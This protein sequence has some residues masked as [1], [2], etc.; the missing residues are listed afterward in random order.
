MTVKRHALPPMPP[1]D[2]LAETWDDFQRH[3]LRDGSEARRNLV[4]LYFFAG[5]A[6]T[7]HTIL[8]AAEKPAPESTTE[9][10]NRLLAEY[11]RIRPQPPV[12]YS[13]L[14]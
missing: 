10:V 6:A 11:D 7:L 8:T 9:T 2:T 3:A 4:R 1:F 14:N 5:V 12:P 13:R